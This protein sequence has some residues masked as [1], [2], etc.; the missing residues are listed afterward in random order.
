M[1]QAS[2]Q[3]VL[4]KKVHE[5]F[6]REYVAVI[7]KMLVL[8]FNL[9]FNQRTL[10]VCVLG[11]GLD[12]HD[13]LGLYFVSKVNLSIS[14]LAIELDEFKKLELPL[15]FNRDFSAN[16]VKNVRSASRMLLNL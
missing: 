14:T 12:C 3:S 13:V 2:T 1:A 8:T 15:H 11:Y 10:L 16:F 9:A 4:Q 6:V 5:I 7:M